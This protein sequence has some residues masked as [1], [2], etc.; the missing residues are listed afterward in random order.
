MRIISTDNFGSDYPDEKFLDL[1][2]MTAAHAN[3]VCDAINVGFGDYSQRC[4][5]S[6]END[7]VLKPGFEP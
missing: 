2:R 1:P 3:A 4:W 5:K 7:Y 6:V